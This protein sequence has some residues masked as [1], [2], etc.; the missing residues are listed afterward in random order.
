[1]P[2]QVALPESPGPRRTLRTRPARAA[3]RPGHWIVR[4]VDQL[5]GLVAGLGGLAA[6]VVLLRVLLGLA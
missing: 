6:L 4:L 1:M 2:A 5:L 3:S